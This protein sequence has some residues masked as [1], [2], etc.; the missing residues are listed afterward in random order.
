MFSTQAM[1]MEQNWRNCKRIN[2]KHE[3][4]KKTTPRR[5]AGLVQKN[6]MHGISLGWVLK[7]PSIDRNARK[8]TVSIKW[9]KQENMRPKLSRE[10]QNT[11][12]KRKSERA[13]ARVHV[14]TYYFVFESFQSFVIFTYGLPSFARFFDCTLRCDLIENG[15]ADQLNY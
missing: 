11:R 15:Q 14:Q 2:W 3:S 9:E 1:A 12:R 7:W 4:Q 5:Q 6:Q 8:E 13:C 10:K